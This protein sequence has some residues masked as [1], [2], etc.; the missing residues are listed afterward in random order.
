MQQIIKQ[1]KY[2]GTSLSKIKISSNS[3]FE[4]EHQFVDQNM[5]SSFRVS[6]HK[7][8]PHP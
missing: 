6:I 7:N 5:K 3:V 4:E 2:C 8:L 1:N